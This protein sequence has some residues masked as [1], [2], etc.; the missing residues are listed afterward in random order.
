MLISPNAA[1]KYDF[2]FVLIFLIFTI[3][4]KVF[5]ILHM[6]PGSGSLF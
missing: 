1:E 4:E 3:G 5:Q 6:L 2:C